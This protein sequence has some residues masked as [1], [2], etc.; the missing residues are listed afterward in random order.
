MEKYGI[1]QPV[2][3]K[4]DIRFV[5]GKGQYTDDINLEGQAHGVILRSPL[6][7]ADFTIKDSALA[8]AMRGVLAVLTYEDVE[9]DSIPPIP[10]QVDIKCAT[11]K[12][13]VHSTSVCACE[14]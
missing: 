11:G 3:R 10:C 4:E 8:K 2:V 6:A 14:G 9:K 1:G 13:N 12:R 5:T 7:H